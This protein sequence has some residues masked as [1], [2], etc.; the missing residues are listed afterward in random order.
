MCVVWCGCT[1]WPSSFAGQFQA[2]GDGSLDAGRG[3]YLAFLEGHLA[4]HLQSCTLSDQSRA[5]LPFGALQLLKVDL[6]WAH[7]L[8]IAATICGVM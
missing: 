7:A 8:K 4:Q 2:G 6:G 3:V 5:S 1:N